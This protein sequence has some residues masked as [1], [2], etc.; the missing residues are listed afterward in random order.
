MRPTTGRPSFDNR[1]SVLCVKTY[2]CLEDPCLSNFWS[3]K[4]VQTRLQ[5][6]KDD[7]VSSIKLESSSRRRCTTP[8]S[9][10]SRSVTP[11]T[12]PK[13]TSHVPVKSKRSSSAQPPKRPPLPKQDNPL[14]QTS[15]YPKASIANNNSRFKPSVSPTLL[16]EMD[17]KNV[18]RSLCYTPPHQYDSVEQTTSCGSFPKVFSSPVRRT[19]GTSQTL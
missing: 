8:V 9:R 17:S 3:R 10:R 6:L 1:P 14:S 15:Y 5:D 19:V 7:F 12:V 13:L 18:Y 11:T 2:N 16:S 4:S